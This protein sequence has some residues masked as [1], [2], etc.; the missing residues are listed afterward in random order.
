MAFQNHI[1]KIVSKLTELTEAGKVAWG[2]T[3]DENTYL[4][5]VGDFIVTLGRG[6]ASSYSAYV[7]RVLGDKGK[8]I[9]EVFVVRPSPGDLAYGN[10][11]R[12]RILHELARRRALH[13]EKSVT[14]LLSSLEQIR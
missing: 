10:W 4:A 3:A 11:D 5:S 1:D 9:D 7:F 12:L 8:V 6:G 2:E 14:D 13:S